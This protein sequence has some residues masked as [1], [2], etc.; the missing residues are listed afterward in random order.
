MPAQTSDDANTTAG[1]PEPITPPKVVG[2]SPIK[3]PIAAFEDYEVELTQS[4]PQ[5]FDAQAAVIG[6]LTRRETFGLDSVL[7]AKLMRRLNDVGGLAGAVE[8][9]EKRFIA[10][11]PETQTANATART[12]SFVA[13]RLFAA[14]DELHEWSS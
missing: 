11:A 6:Q 8:S 4:R 13:D 1:Q 5:N 10:E 2:G 12:T 14:Y 3:P 7:K 9:L